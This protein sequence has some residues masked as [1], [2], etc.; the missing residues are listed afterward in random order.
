[1]RGCC[2]AVPGC[3]LASAEQAASERALPSAVERRFDHIGDA[4]RRNE[5]KQPDT[6]SFIQTTIR[7][8]LPAILNTARTNVIDGPRRKRPRTAGPFRH[9]CARFA[10]NAPADRAAAGCARH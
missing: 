6:D 7:Y 3:W 2:A 4:Y 5:C 1:M 8:L 10:L 9:S